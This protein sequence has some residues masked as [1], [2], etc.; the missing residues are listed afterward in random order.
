MNTLIYN[1]FLT[2]LAYMYPFI[3]GGFA[4]TLEAGTRLKSAV[5][6]SLVWAAN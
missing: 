2:V 5:W 3:L 6:A 1:R 4:R